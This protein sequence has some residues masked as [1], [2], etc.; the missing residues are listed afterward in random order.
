MSAAPQATVHRC[1]HCGKAI[2]SPK[3][4]AELDHARKV[5]PQRGGYIWE[6]ARPHYET[7]Q[8]QD[9]VV[10]ELLAVGAIEPHPDPTKGWIVKW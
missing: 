6:G 10:R 7:G 1:P 2:L 9:A 5:A 3:A 4:H 8:Y